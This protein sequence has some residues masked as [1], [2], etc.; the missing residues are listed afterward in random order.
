MH[1]VYVKN[2][3]VRQEF[4]STLEELEKQAEKY[5]LLPL[6]SNCTPEEGC[7]IITN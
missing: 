5:E 4:F 6:A 3:G 1:M 2:G 7:Y